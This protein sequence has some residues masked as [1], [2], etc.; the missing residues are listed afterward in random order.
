MPLYAVQVLDFYVLYIVNNNINQID[1][2]CYDNAYC[3]RRNNN[4]NIY[5]YRDA[6]KKH[7]L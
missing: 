2:D 5:G 1:G 3:N 4:N 7:Q 6:K